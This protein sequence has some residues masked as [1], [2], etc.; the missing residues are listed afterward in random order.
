MSR[1]LQTLSLTIAALC[2][3]V[4]STN[5]S[6]AF[7]EMV[8]H[9]YSNCSSCHVSPSGGGVLTQYGRELS[10]A[11]LSIWGAENENE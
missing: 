2:P 9:N 8:R 3:L 5:N 1:L 7:P 4:V 10:S 6:W 11:I